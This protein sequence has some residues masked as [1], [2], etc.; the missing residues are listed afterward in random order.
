MEPNQPPSLLLRDGLAD[1]ESCSGIG[2]GI[3]SSGDALARVRGTS[4]RPPELLACASS[5]LRSS[6]ENSLRS[7]RSFSVD[8]GKGVG[9]GCSSGR[10]AS[11][12]S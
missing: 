6:S 4:T 9:R 3:S 12:A 10:V 8:I 1:R 2:G 7:V 11:R 5:V